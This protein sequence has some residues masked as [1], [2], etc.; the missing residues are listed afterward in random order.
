MKTK[1]EF[2]KHVTVGQPTKY[3]RDKHIGMLF[4]VYG[5]GE[6]VEAFCDEATIGQTTFNIW[7]HKH[8]EFQY[9]HDIIINRAARIWARYPKDDP[10]FNVAYW[11][12]MMR[13]RFGYGKAKVKISKDATPLARIESIW[14]GLEKGELSTQEATQLSSVVTTQANIIAN[15]QE[16]PGEVKVDSVEDILAKVRVIKE[17]LDNNNAK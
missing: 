16:E 2:V 14:K 7:L 13:N 12:I 11:S 4:D 1:E 6:G 15:S 5:A 3:K 10:D 17:V 8:E 9:A